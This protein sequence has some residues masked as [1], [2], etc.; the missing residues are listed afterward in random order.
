MYEIQ[1]RDEMGQWSWYSVAG[2]RSAALFDTREE[3]EAALDN[4]A[5]TTGWDRE[6]MRVV[7]VQS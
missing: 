7:E 5:E 1:G 6:A 4:L 2:E 3:A